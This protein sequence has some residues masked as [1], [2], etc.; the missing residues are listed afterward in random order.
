MKTERFSSLPISE[1]FDIVYKSQK[2]I[3]SNIEFSIVLGVINFILLL[4][5]ALFLVMALAK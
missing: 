1:K 5:S 2:C 4:L 3:N